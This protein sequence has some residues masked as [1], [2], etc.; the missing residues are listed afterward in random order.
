MSTEDAIFLLGEGDAL[1]R[2]PKTHYET[3][4]MLQSLVQDHPELLAGEQIDPDDPTRWLLVRREA[5]IPDAKDVSD[6]WSVDHLLLD[7]HGRPTFV[8]VKRSADT[9]IRREVVGQMLDYAANA[10]GYWPVDRIRTMAAES[11]GG[12]EELET[13][14][15]E[16]LGVASDG[17]DTPDTEVF[18]EQVDQNLRDGHVRLLFVADELPRELRRIIEFLN[19]QMPRVDVLGVEIRQYAGENIRALVP[20][21]VGY[22]EATR[23]QKKRAKPS[24]RRT[25]RVE[26]LQS[27]QGAVRAFFQDLLNDAER[28]GLVINWGLKGFSLR[29]ARASGDLVS[30]F[31]GFPAGANER[32]TDYL[33]VYLGYLNEAED[34]DAIR[35]RFQDVCNFLEKGKH[36]LELGLDEGSLEEA[37]KVLEVLWD[38][39]ETLNATKPW[40]GR[41][42]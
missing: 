10:Q 38:V 7:Q 18:W 12:S 16:L 8:E 42:Y 26:F 5:G 33:Q 28:H 13:R 36:T 41:I 11:C 25:T 4:D 35:R 31:Y 21:V 24:T 1:E 14:I 20:R 34:P 37:R 39:A 29:F 9:R 2:V 40:G 19:E 15:R 30:L 22:T 3:E 6:R 17:S 32:P 27:L 23:Q